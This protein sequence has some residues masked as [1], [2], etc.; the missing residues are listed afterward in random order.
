M[1]V[2]IGAMLETHHF[3]FWAF[4]DTVNECRHLLEDRWKLHAKQSGA[5]YKFEELADSVHYFEIAKGAYR[6]GEL[7]TPQN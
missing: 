1:S 5:T 3:T 6:D 4:G 7:R 2:K